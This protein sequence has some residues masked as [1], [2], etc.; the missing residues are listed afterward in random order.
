[1]ESNHRPQPAQILDGGQGGGLDVGVTTGTLTARHGNAIA[2]GRHRAKPAHAHV[3]DRITVMLGDRTH[4]LATVVATYSRDLGFGDA[5]LAPELAAGH[6]TT[7]LLGTIL[8]RT[9]QPGAVATRLRT[10]TRQYP[11]LRVSDRASTATAAGADSDAA[12][13]RWLGPLFVV[14]IFA[15]SIITAVPCSTEIGAYLDLC[16]VSKSHIPAS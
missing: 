2:L 9:A 12:M 13:N 8:V 3:G 11:E 6:Q 5:L 14:M 16:T 4:S 15:F 10:L 7:P 1:M